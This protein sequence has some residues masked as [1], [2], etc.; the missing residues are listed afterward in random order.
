M[1]GS[2]L[3]PFIIFGRDETT[4]ALFMQ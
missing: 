4:P 3:V 1:I 2:R